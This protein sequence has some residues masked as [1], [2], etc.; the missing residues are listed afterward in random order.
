MKPILIVAVPHGQPPIVWW[1]SDDYVVAATARLDEDRGLGFHEA[2][3]RYRDFHG[4]AWWF[5]THAAAREW[6]E[7][8][9]GPHW[10]EVRA[11]IV[12]VEKHPPFECLETIQSE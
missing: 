2:W 10:L 7:S 8:Y 11:E 6:A 3:T 12:Q 5:E 4:D 9:V 1:S